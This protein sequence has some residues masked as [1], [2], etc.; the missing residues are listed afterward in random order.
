VTATGAPKIILR[1]LADLKP[2]PTNARVHGPDQVA[3]IAKSMLEFGFTRPILADQDGIVAGHG[4]ALGA[5]KVYADGGTLR[6]PNGHPIPAGKVPVLDCTGWT[7]EQRR[8]YMLADNQL[9]LQSSW[10]TDLLRAELDD[11]AAADFSF[12]TIGFDTAALEAL[13]NPEGSGERTPPDEF[14]E[15]GEDIVTSH[16]CPKCGYKWSGKAS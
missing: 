9:G 6:F 13:G 12:E 3:A 15:F 14:P 2:S 4:S 16:E 1:D 7:P 8:A 5:A 10:D 11:L